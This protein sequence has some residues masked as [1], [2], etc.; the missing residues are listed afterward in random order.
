MTASPPAAL[1]PIAEFG[2]KA[3]TISSDGI[4]VLVELVYEYHGPVGAA[5]EGAGV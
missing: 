1:C 3:V 2:S 5:A 4:V